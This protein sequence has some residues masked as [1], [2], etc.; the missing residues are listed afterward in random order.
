MNWFNPRNGKYEKAAA[1]NITGIT[2]F[3]APDKPSEAD[4]LLV[5]KQSGK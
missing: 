2:E 1:T 3:K 4:Y 5:I